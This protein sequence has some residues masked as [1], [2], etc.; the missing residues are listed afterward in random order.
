LPYSG[1]VQNFG[2]F[3]NGSI[4]DA[5]IALSVAVFDVIEKEQVSWKG[6]F[7][8]FGTLSAYKELSISG[9]VLGGKIMRRSISVAFATATL[10]I[11]LAVAATAQTQITIGEGTSG[12]V[13][14]TSVGGGGAQI[15]FVGSCGMANCVTGDAYLGS[16]S[17][18][19]AMWITGNNPLL[20]ATS[21][22][23][24]FAVNMN[25][26]TLNFGFSTGGSNY[27]T[28]TIQLTMLKDGTNAP[29]FLGTFT[30]TNS[31]GVFAS[32]WKAGNVIPLDMT[33]SLRQGSA[34]V[35]QV[36]AG[37]AS[38][39]SGNV[40]SGE[41]LNVTAPEPTSIALIGSGLLTIGGFL[42]RRLR[43]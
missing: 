4:R 23:N 30:V 3:R 9:V 42:K 8:Q 7:I 17:G 6:A 39:T 19:Y 29:Q 41:I 1:D 34:L 2:T 16:S 13:D 22:P 12:S 18:Q 38:H 25:G 11:L 27:I 26:G 37:L 28:G 35:D 5:L 21:D 20:S 36:V 43:R 15:S 10:M 32:L 24:I 14:F 33:I 31:N 40:S